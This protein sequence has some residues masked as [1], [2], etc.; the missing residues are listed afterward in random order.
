MISLCTPKPTCAGLAAETL[1]T[2]RAPVELARELRAAAKNLG[3]EALISHDDLA[4]EKAMAEAQGLADRWR[5]EYDT[6]E[7]R[8]TLS[9]GPL[10]PCRGVCPCRQL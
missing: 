8:S 9:S 5:R 1:P 10:R 6:H 2:F 7:L 4:V 3:L